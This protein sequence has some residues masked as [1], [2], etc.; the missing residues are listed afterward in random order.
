[1]QLDSELDSELEEGEISEEE[2]AESRWSADELAPV[3]SDCVPEVG[4]SDE[5]VGTCGSIE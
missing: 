4:G 5:P 3:G 2:H 1:M